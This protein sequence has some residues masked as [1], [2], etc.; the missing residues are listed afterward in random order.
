MATRKMRE[1]M[2]MA[3]K[4]SRRLEWACEDGFNVLCD[5]F[6][7]SHIGTTGKDNLES[8]AAILGDCPHTKLHYDAKENKAW[9]YYGLG[10]ARIPQRAMYELHGF[11][12]TLHFC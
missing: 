11:F 5:W 1:H 10:K 2:K 6:T 7:G 12:S 3:Q 9:I 4:I 8:A